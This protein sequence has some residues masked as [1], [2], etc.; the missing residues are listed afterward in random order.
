[1]I[2]GQ[3]PILIEDDF[4]GTKFQKAVIEKA[5]SDGWQ[6]IKEKSSFKNETSHP[7]YLSKSD[8]NDLSNAP[9]PAR[10]TF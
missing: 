1:M 9:K 3:S 7:W 2:S 8:G 10:K 6:D 5:I 4:R